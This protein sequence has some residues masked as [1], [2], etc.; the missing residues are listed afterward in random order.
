MYKFD[1]SEELIGNKDS[2]NV[3]I[4]FGEL[5]SKDGKHHPLNDYLKEKNNPNI[6]FMSEVLEG[7]THLSGIGLA[8]SRAFRRLYGIK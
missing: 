8:Y 2:I 1:R 5:E 4:S 7:E 3:Y 6:N